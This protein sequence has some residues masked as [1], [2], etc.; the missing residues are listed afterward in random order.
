MMIRNGIGFIWLGGGSPFYKL[1][2]FLIDKSLV[3]W[4]VAAWGW[5][6][7]MWRTPVPWLIGHLP[8]LKNELEL[9]WEPRCNFDIDGQTVGGWGWDPW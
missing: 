1:L 6:G 7:P 9:G 8:L 5:G 4:M 2:V 3:S